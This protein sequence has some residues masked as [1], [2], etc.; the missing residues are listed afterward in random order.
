MRSPAAAARWRAAPLPASPGAHLPDV[1]GPKLMV[2]IRHG[3]FQIVPKGWTGTIERDP[4]RQWPGN[5]FENPVSTTDLSAAQ[6]L[7]Y[8]LDPVLPT[9]WTLV[10]A[11]SG[12][13]SSDPPYGYCA[14]WN[15]EGDTGGV[16]ICGGF[17]EALVG[18]LVLQTRMAGSLRKLASSLVAQPSSVSALRDRNIC[19]L[20]KW[21]F[22]STMRHAAL[23]I[24]SEASTG[25]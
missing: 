4:P 14:R 20:H 18:R 23:R 22:G 10:A 12:D 16:Q 8:W 7:P 5:S 9:D 19:A 1:G 25:H 11:S 2:P 21:K 15:T 17:M 24:T 13:P 6:L 3:S